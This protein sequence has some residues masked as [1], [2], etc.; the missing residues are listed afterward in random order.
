MMNLSIGQKIALGFSA[1][2][3]ALILIG[4]T[5]Y[6]NLRQ[7]EEDA[8]WVTHTLQVEKELDG[9]MLDLMKAENRA[10]AYLNTPDPAFKESVEKARGDLH[11]RIRTLRTLTSDNPHQ[12]ARLDQ[13][14]PLTSA[15][16]DGLLQLTRLHDL[17]VAAS[18]PRM[19]VVARESKTMSEQLDSLVAEMSQ[20]EENLLAQRQARA[21]ATETLTFNVITYGTLLAFVL[22]GIAGWLVSRSITNPLRLLGLGASKI[23]GGD[24]GHRVNVNTKDEVGDLAGLFNRMAIQVEERQRILGDKDWLKTGLTKF[25]QVFQ[26]QRDVEAVCQKVLAELAALLDARHLVLYLAEAAPEGEGDGGLRFQAGYAHDNPAPRLR[27]GQG[28][29]GQAAVD[30]RRVVLDP[31]PENYLKINSVLGEAKP[32][33]IVV[34]P[35]VYEGRTK[36]VIELA[37]LHPLTPV[38]LDFLDQFAESFGVVLN[39]IEAMTRTEALLKESQALSLDLKRNQEELSEKN[40]ALEEQTERL[41]AS[42]MQLQEQQEEL[43]QTNEELEQTNEEMQQT[44]EEM[45]EKVNLLAEQKKQMEKINREIEQAR[46]SIEEKAQELAQTSKYKSDFLAN[47]SHELRTPLNSLLILSK[48]LADNG[49]ENLTEKQ[50]QYAKTIHSSGND[51]LQLINDILDLSKIESGMVELEIVD[52]PLADLQRFVEHTF[53]HVAESKGLA[54]RAEIAPGAPETIRTDVRRL[55]QI[56]KNLLSNA[57]KFTPHGSVDLV[58]GPVEGGW[59]VPNERLDRV[60]T[61]VGFTVKDTGIGV[62]EEK[63]QMIF[64]AFRQGEAGTNRKYGGTGL[65]LSISRELAWQL[66]GSLELKSAPEAGSAFTLYLPLAGPAEL[67]VPLSPAPR[68]RRAAASQASPSSAHSAQTGSQEAAGSA[69]NALSLPSDVED[70]RGNLAPGD[71]ILLIIEDD[72]NFASIMVDFA[73]EKNFKAVV[74]P[75]VEQ[76]IAMA[77]QVVPTAIT[78]DLH[79]PDSEGWI[80]LDQLKHD[81]KTRHIPIHIISVDE[82]RE[83]SLRLGAVSYS[84]KPVTR[85]L[86]QAAFSRTLDFVERP[87]KNLLIVEDNETQRQSMVE[88]IGN[89]DVKTTAV[90]TAAE[91]FKALDAVHFDCMVIDLGLPDMAGIDFIRQ[92]QEKYGAAAPPVIVYTGKELTRK[93]ETDLRRVAESIVIKNVRSPERLLDETALFLHRVQTRLP[94]AARHM[95]EQVQKNDSVIAGRKVL[96]VDDDVR[97]IFALTS[98]LEAAKMVVKYAESGQEGIDILAADPETEIV[99]MDVMMP[100]MDGF[101]AIR[102]IRKMERFR[103]IPIISV[104]AKAMPGD[105]EK[106]LQAGASDYITKPVDI[107]KLKSLLRVWLYR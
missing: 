102:R 27:K 2:M 5:L 26:G 52:M 28:L 12:V 61:V 79:L 77:R 67:K 86:L 63:Q 91:A 4:M 68:E 98:A 6:W 104:T 25:S 49:G 58:I 90:G 17:K 51:L 93:E 64:E 57:F 21:A 34:Q 106:C 8:G 70:D 46:E 85:E 24:Y 48:M 41:Q 14:E 95:I 92:V 56:V 103:R 10:Q 53:R 18:D 16:L 22:V 39:L 29:A 107:E 55:E 76:G 42:E 45:E 72:R 47:M 65:G 94:E 89:G 69:P 30:R 71:R 88:L 54:F 75:S 59:R 101:E 60:G 73:R 81:P 13:F 96:V 87:V 7:V 20:E 100:G 32:R 97:N 50:V 31:I 33:Q 105:R 80:V 37:T 19:D 44:N 38:Q 9:T 66:G 43:K 15:R 82:G 83:R 99:L 74:A 3:S 1:A 78:L 62:S 35:A 23:G 11:S 40:M 36:A 84:Q